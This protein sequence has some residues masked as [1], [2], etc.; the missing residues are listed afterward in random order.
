MKKYLL[1]AALAAVLYTPKTI[2]EHTPD[3]DVCETVCVDDK[4]KGSYRYL[5]V[6][7]YLNSYYFCKISATN[8]AYYEFTLQPLSSSRWYRINDSRATYRWDCVPN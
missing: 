4:V 6:N 7:N 1:L 2:S 3:H 8:G 5:Q